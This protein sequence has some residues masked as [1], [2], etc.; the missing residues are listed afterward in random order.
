MPAGGWEWE[1]KV[2]LFLALEII[3]QNLFKNFKKIQSQVELW[4]FER[5]MQMQKCEKNE[6]NFGPPWRGVTILIL[7]TVLPTTQQ[8]LSYETEQTLH[9]WKQ[10]DVLKSWP[11]FP[12]FHDDVISFLI[13]YIF[14]NKKFEKKTSGFFDFFQ[15]RWKKLK[16]DKK[17][18]FLHFFQKKL[19]LST[20]IE[21][22][23]STFWALGY[24]GSFKVPL[25]LIG[26]EMS[27][28]IKKWK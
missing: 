8:P 4:L 15:K 11:Y 2:N 1:N 22:S 18:N 12:D 24:Y 3:I 27:R 28:E 10:L 25:S 14:K 26:W 23:T 5:K 21:R 9:Q 13:E 7:G 20:K 17:I 19:H 16:K 6:F